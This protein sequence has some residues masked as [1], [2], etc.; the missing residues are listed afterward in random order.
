MKKPHFKFERE[1]AAAGF[2]L[3]AGVD[4]VGRGAWAGPLL[5]AAV[6]LPLHLRRLHN[7]GI[8]DSKMLA[9]KKREELFVEICELGIDYSVGLVEVCELNKWGLGRGTRLAMQRAVDGLKRKPDFILVDGRKVQF[10]KIPSR[11][12]VHGDTLSLSI[13]AASIV[14]KV[15]RDKLVAEI[16]RAKYPEYRFEVHK[17]YG[18]KLHQAMIRKFGICDFHR[19]LF[20]PI[21]LLEQEIINA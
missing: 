9:A 1:I 12:V 8:K 18:T 7:L 5:A 13:A 2:Q 6:I 17:G 15:T 4:E 14:A 16:G 21:Q 20:K 10:S 19:K 11:S 3:I